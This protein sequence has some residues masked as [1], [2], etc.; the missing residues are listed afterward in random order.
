MQFYWK[1]EECDETNA[2]PSV[3]ICETCGSPMTLAAEQRVLREQKEEEKRQAQIKKEQERKRREEQRAKQEAERK[4]QE[5]LKAAQQAELERKRIAQLE[6]ALKK[7]EARETKFA[8]ILRKCTRFSS[9]F[10]RTVAVFAVVITVVLFIQNAENMNLNN[11][12]HGISDNIHA[13]YLAHTIVKSADVSQGDVEIGEQ[14]D[15]NGTSTENEERVSRVLNKVE[16]HISSA[17]TS[18]SKNIEDQITY[19]KNTYKPAD[20]IAALVEDIVE[21]LS[22]GVD[23]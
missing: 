3:K 13:E 21:F 2:Y 14:T 22:G 11:S 20:N 10:M 6:Q 9:G 19:L 4:R 7:R 18:V 1:C 15:Q 5:A 12:L 16:I 23:K 17:F 8:S